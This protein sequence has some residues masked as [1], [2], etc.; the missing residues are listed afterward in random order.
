MKK[1]Y[2]SVTELVGHTPLMELKKWATAMN[3]ESEVLGKLERFNPGGSIKDRVALA[4]I[5]D[6]E[7]KGKLKPGG[8]IIEA[9][10]GN[11][12]IGLT[13]LGTFLGYKVIIV[14]PE[15]MTKER[16]DLMQAYGATLVLTDGTKGMAGAVAKAK[17]L[18]AESDN[19]ILA[20]QFE[21]EACVQAHVETTAPE[22][23]EDT[24]GQV[25]VIVAGVGTGGT[26]TGLSKV[27]REK[28][29]NIYIVA[30]EPKRS[31]VLSTGV[32]GPHGIQGIGAGFIPDI[33]DQNAYN[34]IIA[35]SDED[36]YAMT[37]LLAKEEGILC[38]ISSGAALYGAY[39]VAQRPEFKGKRI[40][41]ILP[42][43][44][45]RY[46]STGIFDNK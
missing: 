27:L 30:I 2:H 16:R 14:M 34:E 32:A 28:N 45:E 42:D 41:A 1:I 11:T 8:T 18:V 46:I 13:A 36:A 17:E 38:G 39:S 4:I 44:G 10:S 29:P 21:N 25:D 20:G 6:A 23:W 5:R 24:D 9:T 7:A 31:A 12:G 19:A 37:K 43:S 15:T 33:L 3:L 26:I 40:V 35:V 22:I